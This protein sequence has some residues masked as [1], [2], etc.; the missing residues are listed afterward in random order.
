VYILPVIAKDPTFL[1]GLNF[2]ALFNMRVVSKKN[3]MKKKQLQ[4]LELL[5]II[6]L[7]IKFLH[8]SGIQYEHPN[9]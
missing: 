9:H 5:C 4:K 6:S 7:K 8:S 1:N 2:A 3:D